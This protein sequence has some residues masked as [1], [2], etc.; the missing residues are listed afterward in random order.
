MFTRRDSF[1]ST[2]PGYHAIR[3]GDILAI[4]LND[5]HV[6]VYEL[7]YKDASV[8]SVNL[9]LKKCFCN[10]EGLTVVHFP[11]TCQPGEIL[12]NISWTFLTDRHTRWLQTPAEKVLY[13]V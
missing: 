1:P 9:K 6:H 7:I 8:T 4:W 10:I 12:Y 11:H 3:K 13:G 5:N 2:K